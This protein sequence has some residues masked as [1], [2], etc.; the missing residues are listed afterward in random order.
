V[1]TQGW[2]SFQ[3]FWIPLSQDAEVG[4]EI[5]KNPHPP[6]LAITERQGDTLTQR[7]AHGF[8]RPNLVETCSDPVLFIGKLP[9]ERV[10]RSGEPHSIANLR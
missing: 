5:R 2:V 4:P 8:Y 10:A 9:G 3:R 7:R 1:L 6:L